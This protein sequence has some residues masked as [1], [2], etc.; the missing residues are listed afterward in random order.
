MLKELNGIDQ[1]NE[2]AFRSRIPVFA[3]MIR[4]VLVHG[5][6]EEIEQV[7]QQLLKVQEPYKFVALLEQLFIADPTAYMRLAR[8]GNQEVAKKRQYYSG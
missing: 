5:T 7:K 8:S 4:S 1:L 3:N 2:R 6:T